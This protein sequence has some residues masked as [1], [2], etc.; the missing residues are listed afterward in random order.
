[1]AKARNFVLMYMSAQNELAPMAQNNIDQI[2]TNMP[3]ANTS[4]LVMNDTIQ[5]ENQAFVTQVLHMQYDAN[6]PVELALPPKDKDV[7]DPNVFAWFLDK[8]FASPDLQ[9]ADLKL[10]VFWGHGRGLEF[11]DENSPDH[12]VTRRA[13]IADFIEELVERESAPAFDVIAFDA[14]Y[15]CMIETLA[16]FT[17]LTR[18]VIVSS[19]EVPE[20]S[21]PYAKIL[22]KLKARS[23]VFKPEAAARMIQKE[24][25]K[26]YPLDGPTG[27]KQLFICDTTKMAACIDGLN[28]LGDS[29]SQLL[30]DDFGDD[31]FRMQLRGLLISAATY[32]CYVSVLTLLNSID[33]SE[34]IGPA[35]HWQSVLASAAKL[36]AAVFDAFQG[37]LG[38]ETSEPCSPLIFAPED[39]VIFQDKIELYDELGISKNG[40]KGWSNF[41]R[42]FHMQ[43]GKVAARA[44]KPVLTALNKQ[45]FHLA[46]TRKA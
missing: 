2:S 30:D 42:A 5:P 40:T 16:D 36:R 39:P 3:M 41:W 33:L 22:S 6:A 7:V 15:M 38:P 10:L 8:A 26:E 35:K 13:N 28:A 24:Y 19:A 43:P 25:G 27:R 11:L 23:T 46:L 1:M 20:E 37:T 31:G 29:L 18:Y 14:C 45:K 32:R 17:S 4:L 44:T 34:P 9:E 21:F 12:S